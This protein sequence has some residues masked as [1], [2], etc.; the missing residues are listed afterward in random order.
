MGQITLTAKIQIYP[1][2][3][4]KELL[5]RT[6]KAYTDGLNFVSDIVYNSH[7][8]CEND[9]SR[10]LYPTLRERFGLKSQQSQSVIKRVLSSYKTIQTHEHGWIRPSFKKDQYELVWDRDAAFYKGR[11]ISVNT[12]RKRIK[13]PYSVK[14]YEQYFNNPKY[15]L[16]TAKLIIK[17]GKYYLHVPVTCNVE[18]PDLVKAQTVVGIDRGLRFIV[19]TYDSDGK[20]SFVN[21]RSITQKRRQYVRIRKRLQKKHTASARRRLRAIGNKEHRWMSDVNHCISKGLVES[22]PAGTLFV[23]EDL[24]GIQEATA[25]VKRKNRYTMC[26]WSYF[27]LEQKL[28]YKARLKGSIVIKV[29]PHYT[30]QRCPICGYTDK[31]N[32]DKKKHIF[33]CQSCG[34]RSNDDRIGAMNLCRL[35]IEQANALV[36]GTVAGEI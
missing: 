4:Q 20:C 25:K 28:I 10:E 26:S 16:G 8:L 15:K 3:E 12:V 36:P 35:G 29:D 34:Y 23:L 1:D 27:D 24:S 11:L 13:V 33:I 31:G 9:L 17:H 32:R 21:G 6:R 14:G 19:T 5:I 22:Y 2:D 18:E 30:S 7:N